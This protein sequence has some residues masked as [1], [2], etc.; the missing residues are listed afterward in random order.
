M[1]YNA[2]MDNGGNVV[3]A[4][5]EGAVSVP[6]VDQQAVEQVAAPVA[7]TEPVVA[8]GLRIED[9]LEEAIK[10]N[11][12]DLHIQV[13]LPPMLRVDGALVPLSNVQVLDGKAVAS[14]VYRVLDEEQKQILLKD[15][16]FDFSFSFGEL[17][18]FRV[19]AFHERGNL[20][21][22]CR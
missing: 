11:A 20:A 1:E 12:S 7:A 14:L 9:F 21:P 10:R 16:E 6:V 15:K 8:T 18:R 19:N 22:A 2:V 4:G 3:E 13:G 17:A 5:Q